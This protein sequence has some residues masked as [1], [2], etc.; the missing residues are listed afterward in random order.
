MTQHGFPPVRKGPLTTERLRELLHY[1][2]ET[3]VFTRKV[4][5]SPIASAGMVAGSRNKRHRHIFIY[6]DSKRYSAHRLAWLYMT[7]A[8]P[9]QKIDHINGDGFDN[10]FTNLRD[11]PQ[12]TNTENQ[13]SGDRSGSSKYL[14]VCWDKNRKLWLSQIK[15]SGKNFYLGHYAVEEDAHRTYVA[16]KRQ[17]HAGCTI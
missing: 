4:S 1:N 8:W 2:P 14:G 7:G 3:G 15:A 13:R 5:T 16:A 12:L 17:L 10:S 11:V 9:K 6:V